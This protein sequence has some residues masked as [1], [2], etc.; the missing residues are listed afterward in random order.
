ME[1]IKR[2]VSALIILPPLVL[3]LIYAPPWLF[4][5]LILGVMWLSLG[6]YF[7]ILHSLQIPK[8]CV[9]ASGLASSLLAATAY[10]GDGRWLAMTLFLSCV[11]LTGSVISA[12]VQISSLFLTL[13]SSLFSIVF[14]GWG[15]SHLILLQHF[16]DGKWYILLLCAIVWVGDSSAMYV[17][18]S[19]GRAKMAPTISPGKTWEGAMAGII[20]GTLVALLGALWW[21]PHLP[22]WH[23]ALIGVCVSV[24]AQMSDLGESI[25]K[26]YAGVKDSGSL[27]P[28]HG[29]MLDRIDSMLFAAPTLVYLLTVLLPIISP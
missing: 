25:I 28:G 1:Q 10:I 9:I 29:G 19:L 8:V 24:T 22:L 23:A 7:A 2:I 15:L 21:F 5:S 17:G 20:G 16:P 18:K 6:E 27:I 12:A 14:I 11:G 13:I 3:F 4:F 26:R